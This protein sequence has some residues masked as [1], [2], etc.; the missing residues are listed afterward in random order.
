MN[1]TEMPKSFQELIQT[2]DKPLLVDFWADWCMPCKMLAPVLEKL[3]KEWK[4]KVTV[5]KIDT[6]EKPEL[7]SQYGIRGIPTLILF[8]NGRE[9]KRTSGAM[10]LEALKKEYEIFI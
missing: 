9:V 6:E 3:A 4:G 8:K 1:K 5:I 7:A 10:P 2:H